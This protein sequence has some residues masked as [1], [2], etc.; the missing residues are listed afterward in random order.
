MYD[1]DGYLIFYKPF[2]TQHY[3]ST[4]YSML[5]YKPSI[6]KEKKRAPLICIM[7]FYLL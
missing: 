2:I 7:N 5:I 3:I 4:L 6:K 1:S